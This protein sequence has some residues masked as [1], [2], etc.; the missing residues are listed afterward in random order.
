MTG[1]VYFG[2]NVTLRGTVIVVANE[3]QRIDIP[4]G[5]ILE[6]RLLSGNLNM[7]VSLAFG[8]VVGVESECDADA[9]HHIGAVISAC[10]RY[11]F[12]NHLPN[13]RASS[14][15]ILPFHDPTD[16]TKLKCS[17][18]ALFTD[19]TFFVLYGARTEIHIRLG[20]KFTHTITLI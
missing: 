18:F 5:C 6:N 12:K 17:L 14:I 11:R 9:F 3:G 15:C 20:F 8:C 2:R 7:I 1:D 4:D 16:N 13:Y 19:T 10:G